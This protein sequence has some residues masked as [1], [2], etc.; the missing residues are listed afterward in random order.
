MINTETTSAIKGGVERKKNA[1]GV[2]ACLKCEEFKIK[3]KPGKPPKKYC[4][5]C[6]KEIK[7]LN[8]KKVNEKK[9]VIKKKKDSVE[10]NDGKGIYV[11]TPSGDK[12]LVANNEEKKFYENRK[13]DL[14]K[15]YDFNAAEKDQLKTFLQL[16]LEEKR[17]DEIS[18]GCTDT[19][20]I[21]MLLK[22]SETKMAIA[23][24][25]GI[26]RDQ[27]VVRTEAETVEE[28]IESII[29]RFEDLRKNNK[30]RFVW[31]CEKCG[32]KNVTSRENPDYK[33]I[34]EHPKKITETEVSITP[35]NVSQEAVISVTPLEGE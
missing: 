20:L 15:N 25:M 24:A 18:I 26:T 6:G 13:N 29:D 10:L 30:D 21:A 9:V 33:K 17:L 34:N 12:M 3:A 35:A 5:K 27:R 31:K 16:N 28:A 32:H 8:L 22:I 19:K 2:W 7:S 1:F 23:K 4:M 11:E 14:L